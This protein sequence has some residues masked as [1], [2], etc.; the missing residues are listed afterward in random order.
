MIKMV[1]QYQ[2]DSDMLA[3]ELTLLKLERQHLKIHLHAATKEKTNDDL[4]TLLSDRGVE[5]TML[6][7][8]CIVGT[9]NNVSIQE[10]AAPMRL[11]EVASEAEAA[12]EFTAGLCLTCY[13]QEERENAEEEVARA[14]EERKEEGAL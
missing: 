5:T 3:V 4:F 12:S 8:P 7:I 10:V 6:R 9:C 13:E 11:D 1:D 2:D 14:R